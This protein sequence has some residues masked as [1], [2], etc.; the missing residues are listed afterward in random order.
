MRFNEFKPQLTE[1]Q[2]VLAYCQGNIT[3]EDAVSHL[4]E[5]KI[6][7]DEES[8]RDI[9]NKLSWGFTDSDAEKAAE[10][11]AQDNFV[12]TKGL[13]GAALQRA[14]LKAGQAAKKAA[15]G[16]SFLSNLKALTGLDTGGN[17]ANAAPPPK[18]FTPKDFTDAT[19]ADYS[20]PVANKYAKATAADYS[21]PVAKKKRAPVKA[22]A[23]NT[24]DY[25]KT[26]ALQKKLIAGGAKI[27]ADGLMGPNTRAA[28]KAA[29]M[30]PKPTPKPTAK[31][32]AKP[33][34]M[35]KRMDPMEPGDNYRKPAS[36]KIPGMKLAY[37]AKPPAAKIPPAPVPQVPAQ[38]KKQS[39][40]GIIGGTVAAIKRSN[41]RNRKKAAADYKNNPNKKVTIPGTNFSYKPLQDN[42]NDIEGGMGA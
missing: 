18:D 40:R 39:G 14:K 35:P 37:T 12:N 28:M 25:D 29:G 10:K 13:T 5:M 19:A 21:G 31:P 27:K 8:W 1:E 7:L 16:A 6:N 11:K 38:K 2:I 26:M 22:T 15:P 23:A 24:R 3:K 4:S 30:S 33:K 20:G 36:D 17:K 42:P 9:F 34:P 32:T 41:Q